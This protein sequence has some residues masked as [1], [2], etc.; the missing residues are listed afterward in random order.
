MPALAHFGLG[1]GCKQITQK[2]P[3]IFLLIASFSLRFDHFCNNDMAKSLIVD[4]SWVI[5]EYC[6]VDIIG[7]DNCSWNFS[8]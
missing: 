1:F 6:V 2:I 8:L 5:Y 4:I 3:V 7:G